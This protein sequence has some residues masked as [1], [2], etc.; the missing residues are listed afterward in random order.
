MYSPASEIRHS[1][2][3]RAWS[4]AQITGAISRWAEQYGSPPVSG[5]WDL[6]R[7][8][9][10]AQQVRVERLQTGDWPS[11]RVV[12]RVFGTFNAAI[13]QAGF[14]PRPAPSRL[15]TRRYDQGQ[16]ERAIRE[17]T[18]RYGEPPAMSDWDVYRAR[19][20]GHEWRVERYREGDWPS[21]RTVCQHFGNFN[22][23]IRAAGLEPRPQGLTRSTRP[24]WKQRNR[25]ALARLRLATLDGQAPTQLADRVNAVVQARH[26]LDPLVLRG[27][28]IDLA[29]TALG[30][31]DILEPE[32][33]ADS[34]LALLAG[35]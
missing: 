12:R 8:R 9:R 5:D 18:G 2:T 7:A 35:R 19:R 34:A 33:E 31:A 10:H 24:D 28:L 26:A 16:I 11:T 25:A 29:A 23:A 20:Q 3:Q 13:A 14:T 32:S 21:T 27:S 22:N 17:W 30:W 1:P 6:S 4:S 15:A